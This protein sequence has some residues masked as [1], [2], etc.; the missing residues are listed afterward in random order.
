MSGVSV[1][2][3]KAAI[4]DG[5]LHELRRGR[6]EVKR[7]DLDEWVRENWQLREP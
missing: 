2:V 7:A 6:M 4:Y 1:H 5:T 3:R